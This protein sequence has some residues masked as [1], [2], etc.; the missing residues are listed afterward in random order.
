MTKKDETAFIDTYIKYRGEKITFVLTI[1]KN[2]GKYPLKTIINAF[3][4]FG[5]LARYTHW[6]SRKAKI[7]GVEEQ[8]FPDILKSFYIQE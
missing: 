5:N 6:Y 4:S 7:K 1:P 8:E 3:W 2:I